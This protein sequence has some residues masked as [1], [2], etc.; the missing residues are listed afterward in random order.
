MRPR[1]HGGLPV[2][3]WFLLD[4]DVLRR[5][6]NSTPVWKRH[7]RR[8]DAGTFPLSCSGGIRLETADLGSQKF[9]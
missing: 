8:R 7:I 5:E 6:P 2:K 4:H 3:S 1:Q 9:M